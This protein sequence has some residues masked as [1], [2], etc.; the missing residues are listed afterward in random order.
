MIDG[1]S[2]F[3]MSLL[4][5]YLATPRAQKALASKPLEDGFSL[6]ELVVVVAVLAILSAIAI[7]QFSSISAQAAHAAA[8]NTLATV[9]KECAVQQAQLSAT[10]THAAIAG[11]NNVHFATTG[12]SLAAATC[13][14]A[15]APETVCAFVN[16]GT[17]ATYCVGAGGTKYTGALAGVPQEPLTAFSPAVGGGITIPAAEAW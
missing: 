4:K 3:K 6:I 12:A 2:E 13:G 17:A 8:K 1:N 14:T 7:P 11:G 15:A 16:A 9:A 10:A 5:A